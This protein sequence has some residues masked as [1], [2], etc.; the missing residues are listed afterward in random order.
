MLTSLHGGHSGEYCDHASGKLD[1]FVQQAI[2]S[3]FTHYGFSEH[4]PRTRWQD[5]YPEERQLGRTPDNLQSMFES[6]IREARSLQQ[7]YSSQLQ[8]LVGM[9]TEVISQNWDDI[10][11]LRK[12][13]ELDYLVGSVHFVQG[14]SIDYN[15]SQFAQAENILGGT[16]QVFC[17]YFDIQYQLMQHIQPEVIGHFDLIRLFRPDFPMTPSIWKRVQ[18]N[19]EYAIS[20]GALFEV[21]ARAYKNR[22]IEPYPQKN[23][24]QHIL[25]MN[26]KLTLGDDSHRPE[27]VGYSFDRVFEFLRHEGVDHLYGLQYTPEGNLEVFTF[28]FI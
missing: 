24:L 5:L 22:L 27:E 20:Y 26:G 12:K 25:E 2:R 21:N 1:D 18:R 28:L 9:E 15:E 7:Y 17:A 8:I 16:E 4:M 14:I 6:Y 10:K 23:I 11:L 19:V 13:F 3:G